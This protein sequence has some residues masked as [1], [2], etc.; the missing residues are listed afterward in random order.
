MNDSEIL[1]IVNGISI[2]HGLRAS[3]LGDDSAMSVGVGGDNRSYTRIIVLEGSFPGHELLADIS[4]KI[5][6]LTGVNRV[7]FHITPPVTKTP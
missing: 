2:P 6:N 5:S 3:F 7:T 1:D 4:T